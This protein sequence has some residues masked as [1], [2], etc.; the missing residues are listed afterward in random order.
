MPNAIQVKNLRPGH[1]WT[2]YNSLGLIIAIEVKKGPYPYCLT[3]LATQNS[4]S[5]LI[6]SH[7]DG[8]GYFLEVHSPNLTEKNK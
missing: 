4:E 2:S 3:I 1:F 7:W 6:E 8:A 5:Q